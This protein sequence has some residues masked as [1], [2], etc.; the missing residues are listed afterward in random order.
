MRVDILIEIL[1]YRLIHPDASLPPEIISE[2]IR[3]LADSKRMD[4][5]L[6]KEMRDNYYLT[7]QVNDLREKL[8]RA[9]QNEG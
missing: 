9:T 7:H 4:E 1:Q 5:Q 3:A 6:Y 8:I 2:I